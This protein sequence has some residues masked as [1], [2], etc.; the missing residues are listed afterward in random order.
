MNIVKNLILYIWSLF[1]LST[2]VCQAW[3][4]YKCKPTQQ[5]RTRFIC[6]KYDFLHVLG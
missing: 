2:D 1:L 4:V 3:L 5:N 6:Y